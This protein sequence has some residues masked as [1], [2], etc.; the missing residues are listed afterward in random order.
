[1][2]G[3]SSACGADARVK[4]LDYRLV[5]PGVC[6][7]A[8][9]YGLARYAYGL[10]LPVFREVFDL[11]D[12]LL[13]LTAA[14]SYA[15]YFLITLAGIY[16][17]TRV[18]PRLSVLLGGLAAALG[19]ALIAGATAPW[20]LI[21]G[22]TVAGVSPGLAYTP[23]SEIIVT[24]V[25]APR[26]KGIY[27]VINSGTSLGVMLSGPVAILLGESWRM[28]WAI[29]AGFGLLS[30]LWCVAILPPVAA[31]NAGGFGQLDWRWMTTGGRGRLFAVAFLIG[32]A[33]SIYWA[34][35]VDLVTAGRTTIVLA[36]HRLDPATF[37]QV[38]WSLV[39]L[40]G[41]AGA[42]AGRIVGRIGP[43]RSLAV[44]QAGIA[45][46]TLMLAAGQ[47]PVAVLGSGLVFG[48]FFVFM[49]ATL[50]MWSLDLSAE[51]PAVGFGLTFLLLSAG[52]FV[53]PMLVGLMIGWVP[54]PALFVLAGGA[55]L[56]VL[57]LL[58]RRSVPAL[59]EGA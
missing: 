20:M 16:L 44:F 39:G 45:V 33:T 58:P 4:L 3:N 21:L 11:S 40:A 36:G 35:S 7:V 18:G 23:F 13:A 9:S 54:L 6:I 1:M 10:F 52:Q 48:G 19:M 27:S 56:A 41:F 14:A 12:R 2:H 26:R 15:S 28:A 46:A 30:T 57:A 43:I 29:F 17:S 31:R 49:A 32:I 47:G 38:F 59:A 5:A 8:T 55:S 53:G 51:A 22:V 50:G 25:T 34:F 42:F 37:G 24:L